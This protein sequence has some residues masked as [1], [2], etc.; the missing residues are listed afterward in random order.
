MSKPAIVIKLTGT[1]F[2][3]QQ[4]KQLCRTLAESIVSQLQTLKQS[5]QI[6]IV[7]GGGAFFRGAENNNIL[8]VRPATAH[9]IGMLATVA[10]ALLLYDLLHEHTIASTLLCACEC[11]LAGTAIS[12]QSIDDA[13]TQDK[14][15][16]FSGGTGN[17]YVS[18]DTAAVIRAK[19]LG[20]HELWK[21]TTVDGVYSSDPCHDHTA[22]LIPNMTHQEA[23]DKHLGFMDYTAMA[24]AQQEQLPMRIFNVATPDIFNKLAH[25]ESLGSVICT[26]NV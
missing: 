17:P 22:Q 1:L 11:A 12:Q 4:A 10:N 3:D 8:K 16:I 5:Y 9:T 25:G 7:I 6:G 20:A 14:I 18:S 24:L 26:K 15:I 13:I 21:A 23:L 2:V 19:Q